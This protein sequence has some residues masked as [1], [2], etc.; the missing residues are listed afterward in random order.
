MLTPNALHAIHYEGLISDST[1]HGA[2]QYNFNMYELKYDIIELK[3]EITIT[4]RR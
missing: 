2:L 3:M 4:G 1:G